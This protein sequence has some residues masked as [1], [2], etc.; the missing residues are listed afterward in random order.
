MINLIK[1]INAL[2]HSQILL[3]VMCGGEWSFWALMN[4]LIYISIWVGNSIT[5]YLSFTVIHTTKDNRE[6]MSWQLNHVVTQPQSDSIITFFRGDC[7]IKSRALVEP[8]KIG[9]ILTNSI[10]TSKKHKQKGIIWTPFV[11]RQHC[12]IFPFLFPHNNPCPLGGWLL[13]QCR[14]IS[15]FNKRQTIIV[16]SLSI[17]GSD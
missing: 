13:N 5:A 9:L 10:N 15:E 4:I 3:C 2:I 16:S 8:T 6:N 11:F 12:L 1:V 14:S 17:S 7:F